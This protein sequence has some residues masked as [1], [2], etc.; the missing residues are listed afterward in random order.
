MNMGN[1]L[2]PKTLT[3]KKLFERK[4]ECQNAQNIYVLLLFFFFKWKKERGECRRKNKTL[5]NVKTMQLLTSS[6]DSGN[7]L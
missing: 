2:T 3:R 5:Q 1:K 4:T 7:I 6:D